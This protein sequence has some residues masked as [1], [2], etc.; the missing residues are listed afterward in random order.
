MTLTAMV[1]VLLALAAIPVFGVDSGDE[2]EIVEQAPVSE[3]EAEGSSGLTPAIP[4]PE[5]A[6]LEPLPDW[7][8]RYLVPTGLALALVVIIMTSVQYF[9]NVVRKRYRI[10]EE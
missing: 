2:D 6:A 3:E 4:M 8:Y 5:E 10:V 9:M 7:T 1:F